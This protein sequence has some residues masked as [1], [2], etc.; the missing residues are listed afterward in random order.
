MCRRPK[1]PERLRRAGGLFRDADEEGRSA[2]LHRPHFRL[3]AAVPVGDRKREARRVGGPPLFARGGQGVGRDRRG[4]QRADDAAASGVQVPD[5]LLA[6]LRPGID[7][8][9][10]G[11]RGE[12]ATYLP[13]SGSSC[14]TRSSSCVSW[15]SK[16]GSGPTPGRT[17]K[18]PF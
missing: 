15:P 5:D 14:R 8:V 2:R 4:G 1:L 13:R 16:P 7:G 9:V 12:R 10:F 6:K 11:L 18:P 17:P 3:P